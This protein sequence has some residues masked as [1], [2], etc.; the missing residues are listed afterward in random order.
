MDG[1]LICVVSANAG[2]RKAGKGAHLVR[3]LSCHHRCARLWLSFCC[4]RS[5][6]EE[7]AVGVA[8]GRISGLTDGGLRPRLQASG[9]EFSEPEPALWKARAGL[10]FFRAGLG[11]L[12][13]LRHRERVPWPAVAL[14]NQSPPSP[15]ERATGR[16][17]D[18]LKA[19]FSNIRL[20]A[21]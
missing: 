15:D 11:R 14:C 21:S 13:A 16:R 3:P 10:G 1:P 5:C 6:K 4:G 19:R 9:F 8:Q 18:L 17:T 20:N 2:S 7:K 12:R